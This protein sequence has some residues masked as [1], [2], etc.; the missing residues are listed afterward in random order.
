MPQYDW[1]YI[2]KRYESGE[3]AYAISKR[4]GKPSKQ[5]IMKRASKE[6]WTQVTGSGP[7]RLPLVAAAL[8][9]SASKLT[10]EL[11]QIV[12]G[13]IADGATEGMACQA[14]GISQRTWKIG[15]AHV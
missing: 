12:L 14:A 1:P 3:T 13:L 4:M 8:N 9:I 15:R 7:E 2:R 6:G 11:L 5:A 10:D